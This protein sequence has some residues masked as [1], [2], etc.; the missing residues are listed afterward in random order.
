[1]DSSDVVEIIDSGDRHIRLR[2]TLSFGFLPLPKK[3]W[4]MRKILPALPLFMA[5]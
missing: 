2:Y 4:Q 3:F 1:M 5:I